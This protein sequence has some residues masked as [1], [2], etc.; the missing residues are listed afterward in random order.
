MFVYSAG[1]ETGYYQPS[2][3]SNYQQLVLADFFS[4]VRRRQK[5][6]TPP[7]GIPIS[8]PNPAWIDGAKQFLGIHTHVLGCVDI[9]FFFAENI[10]NF[11]RKKHVP[12]QAVRIFEQK[13]LRRYTVCVRSRVA[14]LPGRETT[15]TLRRG[16]EGRGGEGR[17]G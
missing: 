5:K 9:V 6:N 14:Y 11:L 17:A 13:P 1:S 3:E 12:R 7:P 16:R 4:E 15:L 2:R 8:L 10:T